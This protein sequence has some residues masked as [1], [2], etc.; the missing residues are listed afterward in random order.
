MA[1]PG[2]L[3]SKSSVPLTPTVNNL[4]MVATNCSSGTTNKGQSMP[5]LREGDGEKSTPAKQSAIVNLAKSSPT[6]A[7][8]KTPKDFIFGK[9]IGEGSFSTVYLAKD[10]HSNREFASAFIIDVLLVFG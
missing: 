10:V 2:E 8:K 4:T 1:A 5:Q 6:T 7:A 3:S 9:V